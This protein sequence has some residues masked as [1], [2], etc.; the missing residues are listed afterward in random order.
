MNNEQVT[1]KWARET[2]QA[3]LGDKVKAEL[4][5]CLKAVTNAV[6]KNE[7]ST[8]VGFTIHSLTEKELEK[9]GFTVNKIGMNSPDPREGPYITISW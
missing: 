5:T 6:S 1:A 7:L 9:R 2:A 8:S 3:L 4:D